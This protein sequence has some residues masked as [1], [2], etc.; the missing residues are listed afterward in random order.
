MKVGLIRTL[1]PLDLMRRVV[2]TSSVVYWYRWYWN[3]FW[4]RNAECFCREYALRPASPG[5]TVYTNVPTHGWS[6]YDGRYGWWKFRGRVWR[7]HEQHG[8]RYE[9]HG[10]E[11]GGAPVVPVVLVLVHNVVIT[12]T[13][14]HDLLGYFV[15]NSYGGFP[16]II[17]RLILFP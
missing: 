4:R 8:E 17:W 13:P 9:R 11:C 1:E 3:G 10:H 7:W 5:C 12:L 6:W 16:A 15:Q 2:E 14:I